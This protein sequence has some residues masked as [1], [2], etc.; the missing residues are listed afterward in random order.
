MRDYRI[1]F[2]SVPWERA[3]D[4]VRQKAV[5]DGGKKLRLV[6]YSKAMPL[7]WCEKGH[8]GYILQGR[9]EIEFGDGIRVFEEGDGVFIPDGEK[10]KHRAR[11]LADVVKVVFVE[12]A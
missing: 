4:G 2:E 8:W 7:H 5:T 1:D 6:E 9:L 3:M 12:D 10:H 11:V